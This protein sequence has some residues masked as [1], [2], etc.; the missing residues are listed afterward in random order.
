MYRNMEKN[1]PLDFNMYEFPAKINKCIKIAF[2]ADL[3]DRTFSRIMDI[4]EKNRPDIVCIA[5]DLISWHIIR[6]NKMTLRRYIR[7]LRKHEINV[8]ECGHL[9][10]S[11]YAL[12]FLKRCVEIAPT[13]YSL[14]N[15]EKYFDAKDR[16]CVQTAGARLLD[17]QFVIYNDIAIGGLTSSYVYNMGTLYQEASTCIMVNTN[18]ISNKLRGKQIEW[19]DDFE[20]LDLFKILLCHHPKYYDLYLKDRQIDLILAGHAHGGQIRIGKRGLYAP[21]QGMFPQYFSGLYHN[22]ML[23]SRGIANVSQFVPRINNNREV[24]YIKLIPMN[25]G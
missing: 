7:I 11:R 6:R 21:G 1:P 4:F 20:K 24:I 23:V 22:R 25:G 8:K 9:Y 16:E 18:P 19:L 15:N 14:G 2:I 10:T 5:G 17:N 3:H 12:D 13:F